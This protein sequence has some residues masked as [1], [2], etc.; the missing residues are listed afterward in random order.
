[1][2]T[3]PIMNFDLAW[4]MEKCLLHAVTVWQKWEK[5]DLMWH[6]CIGLLLLELR[7]ENH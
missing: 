3:Q 6:L 2:R 5:R 7:G 4:L 1:M